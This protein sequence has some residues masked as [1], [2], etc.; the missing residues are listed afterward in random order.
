MKFYNINNFFFGLVSSLIITKAFAGQK[1]VTVKENTVGKI[2]DLDYELWSREGKSSAIFNEDGSFTCQYE[3][4]GDT[5]CKMGYLLNGKKTHEQ[6]GHI[7]AEYDYKLFAEAMDFSYLSIYGW[8]ENPN[9]NQWPYVEKIEF[10][11]IGA[12]LSPDWNSQFSGVELGEYSADNSKYTV[13]QTNEYQYYSVIKKAKNKRK[14]DVTAHL[15][16]LEKLGMTLGKIRELSILVEAGSYDSD[17]SGKIEITS[18]KIYFEDVPE[19][20]SVTV[21]E[22]TVGTVGDR[23][24]ELWSRDG[25]SS[26]TFN[27][28]GSFTCQYEDTGDTMCKSGYLLD[29][30][31][32]YEQLGQIYAE[33]ECTVFAKA[34]DYSYLSIYGW[35]ENPNKNQW[36][37]VEKVEFNI[38]NSI[39][40]PDWDKT[41]SGVELGEYAVENSKFTVYQT[42]QYQYYSVVKK[43]NK[44]K[45]KVDVTAHL[46]QLEKLGMTLGKIRE[47]SILI[48]AG[49]YKSESSGK[50]EVTSS[51]ISFEEVSKKATCSQAILDMGYQC[52]SSNC[53]VR[54]TDKDGS[55]GIEKEEWCGCGIESAE[56]TNCSSKIIA[57]GYNCCPSDCEVIF[58]DKDGSWGVHDGEW[59][60]CG[61]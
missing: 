16:Q 1:S 51:K 32:T 10:N 33:Y 36:P 59:C 5:M 23:D 22:N 45:G 35:A 4:T 8:I 44:D 9:K 18:S 38:I 39:L 28:D 37:Y 43:N 60:G 13:Y 17:S 61:K 50:I 11:I 57:Y 55:W 42:N 27:K 53:K 56:E 49:S 3:D 7:Y 52:C 19:E 14:V 26:A 47:I 30:S 29:G 21:K 25:K 20:N 48:E 12:S 31:K 34:M 41:F 40:S 2:G 15:Q 58:V 6:L 46:K 54:F 24:F